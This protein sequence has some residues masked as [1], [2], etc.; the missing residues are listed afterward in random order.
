[1]F[2]ISRSAEELQGLHRRGALLPELRAAEER[3]ARKPASDGEARAWALSLPALARDLVEA[4]LGGV[5][6]MIEY[7]LPRLATAADVV[8]AGV[9]PRKREPSYVVAELKQWRRVTSAAGK[10]GRFHVDSLSGKPKKHPA[11]QTAVFCRELLRTYPDVTGPDR[12]MGLAYLHNAAEHDVADLLTYRRT[13]LSHV[14]TRDSRGALMAL[15][16]AQLGPEPGRAAA[17]RFMEG[18][19]SVQLGG[20][21]DGAVPGWHE[22][23]VLSDVRAAEQFLLNAVRAAYT[24]DQKRVVLVSG[25]TE[26]H[27]K[28][29]ISGVVRQLVDAGY[30]AQVLRGGA[31]PEPGACDVLFCEAAGRRGPARGDHVFE[32]ADDSTDMVAAAI[33]SSRVPVFVVDSDHASLLDERRAESLTHK[34]AEAMR[35]PV[36]R[37]ELDQEFR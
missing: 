11:E 12:L 9:H 27:R 32:G 10:E 23:R 15:L 30:A 26:A 8:L 6:M 17:D 36:Q 3:Q 25:I 18:E 13:R 20:I 16:R 14:F 34:T 1:M 5:E 2:L 24:A 7:E 29:L 35:I 4:G 33:R 28:R 31:I 22:F 21:Q 19:L 37:I